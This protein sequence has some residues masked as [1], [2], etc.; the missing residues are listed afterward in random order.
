MSPQ[1]ILNMRQQMIQETED[2]LNRQLRDA[3]SVP[4]IYPRL[5]ARV[6]PLSGLMGRSP[7]CPQM[8]GQTEY[9][10]N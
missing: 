1:C 5:P 3:Q 10:R 9:P 4:V 6:N 8:P 7:R 2:F